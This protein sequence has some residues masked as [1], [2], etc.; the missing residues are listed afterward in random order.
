M[1]FGPFFHVLQLLLIRFSQQN[2][3]CSSKSYDATSTKNWNENR[4]SM[5]LV[6]VIG[7]ACLLKF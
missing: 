7:S 1:L 6:M 3:S 4:T 5:A 2:L